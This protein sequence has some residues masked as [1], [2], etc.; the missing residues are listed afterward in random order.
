MIISALLLFR[1]EAEEVRRRRRL[2]SYTLMRPRTPTSLRN[3]Y[4][5]KVGAGLPSHLGH[6][7]LV[8][9][10]LKK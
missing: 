4:L 10:N 1:R 8:T 6:G 5:S 3:R 9:R 2:T 7:G